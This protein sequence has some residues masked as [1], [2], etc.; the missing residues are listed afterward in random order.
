MSNKEYQ[1]RETRQ[2]Q[3]ELA[4]KLRTWFDSVAEFSERLEDPDYVSEQIE[5]VVNGS[6]GAGFCF[7]LQ[8]RMAQLTPRM[9][10]PAYIGRFFLSAM[11]GHDFTGWQ[12]LTGKAQ[13]QV[14]KAVK[15][16]L[17]LEDKGYGQQLEA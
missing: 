1:Q 8:R 2:C 16:W 5:W 17:K 10:A 3:R 14:T 6:Y 13:R 11:Y 15:A 12:R 9:N 7:E 4:D